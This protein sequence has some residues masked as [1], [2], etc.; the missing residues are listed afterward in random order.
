M[1]AGM[2]ADHELAHA[3]L[4]AFERSPRFGD[5]VIGLRVDGRIHEMAKQI[6]NKARQARAERDKAQ[7][8]LA[9]PNT[10]K[11]ASGI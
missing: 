6:I 7:P 3:L 8:C 11:N 9:R 5:R 4:D 1:R 2:N 10:G